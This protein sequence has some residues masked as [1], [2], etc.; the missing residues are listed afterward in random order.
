MARRKK[1]PICLGEWNQTTDGNDFSCG[2]G[3]GFACEDCKV[4]GG[5]S[6]PRD[7][8]PDMDVEPWTDDDV[9]DYLKTSRR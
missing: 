1:I 5:D 7:G 6:D 9:A 8:D 2:Y 4:N 3:V